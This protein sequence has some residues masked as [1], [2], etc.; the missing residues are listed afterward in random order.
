M[1]RAHT[2]RIRPHERDTN[3]EAAILGAEINVLEQHSSAVQQTESNDLVRDVKRDYRNHIK[4]IYDFWK[5]KYPAY[6]AVGVRELADEE[7]ADEDMFWHRNKC[8][9]VYEGINVKM[10]KAFLAAKK[11]KANGK[12]SSVT[13]LQKYNDAI[14]YGAK[15]AGQWLPWSYFEEMEKFFGAY[16]KEA[17]SAKK[18]GKLDEQEADPISW[19]LFVAMLEWALIEEKNVFLWVFTLLQ[20]HCMA[21]SINIG[22]LAFHC[23]QVGEDNII[24]EYD[25]QKADQTG[26]KLHEKHCYE[27]PFKPLVSLFLAMGVWFCINASHFE[28]T[29]MLFQNDGNEAN[30]ASQQYCTQ[31]VE[32]FKKYKDRL[33][34]YIHVDH[35]NTHGVHK[36]SATSASSGTTCPPPVSSLAARG[37]W[38]LGHILD[39]YWHFAEPGDA[40]LGRVLAGLDPNGEEFGT[41][42]PHW[43]ID[44]PMSNERIKEGMNLMFATILQKWGDTEVDPTGILL[45]CLASVVYNSDFLKAT[46]A[47]D[48]EHPFN[49]IPLLSNPQLL[50]DLKELVMLEPI[51]HVKA[52]TGI[53]PHVQNAKVAKEILNTCVDTLKEVKEMATTV[54]EAVNKAFEEKAVE[55]GQLTGQRLPEII[56][57]NQ[58]SMAEMIDRKLS[59]LR[60]E[61]QQHT[62]G[63]STQQQDDGSDDDE[64]IQFADGEEEQNTEGQM[65]I[66]Y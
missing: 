6:Y 38:S 52:A 53:P 66:R 29:E 2:G 24:V 11:N 26:E 48:P 28:E 39:L 7:L 62:V 22:V 4:H 19:A 50:N 37:E 51:G 45:L 34:Q 54:Q 12:V 57:N 10:V 36:G 43:N 49:L 64:Q 59:E 31:L 44:D 9:L 20:W 55:N 63:M 8:D 65:H 5:E 27:N 56:T 23:F 17:A 15:K 47:A 25:K 46:A 18:E 3:D 40:Y 14:L 33:K 60:T 61:I 32:L 42:P 21:Q 58:E 1:P 35:A 13:H 30:A 16:K 41:L